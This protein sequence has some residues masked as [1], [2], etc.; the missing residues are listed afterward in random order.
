[1]AVGGS[2]RRPASERRRWAAGRGC[3][4]WETTPDRRGSG[5]CGIIA[6]AL[7]A[8]FGRVRLS[9]PIQAATRPRRRLRE[10][11]ATV[12]TNPCRRPVLGRAARTP[13]LGPGVATLGKDACVGIGGRLG[14]PVRTVEASAPPRPH[15]E[16]CRAAPRLTP[17]VRPISFSWPAVSRHGSSGPKT[18]VVWQEAQQSEPQPDRVEQDFPATSCGAAFR[19]LPTN[20][21]SSAPMPNPIS[22]TPWVSA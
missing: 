19:R 21:S 9:S 20:R 16:A 17:Y 1:M 5:S 3:W 12:A 14:S 18:G 15:P 8:T 22:E 13:S 4:R 2:G 6:T 11:G 10:A 7:V